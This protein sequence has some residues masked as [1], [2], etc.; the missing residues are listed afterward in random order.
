MNKLYWISL[1][2]ATFGVITDNYNI[3]TEAAPIGKWMIGKTIL[4]VYSWVL[5]KRGEIKEIK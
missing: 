5:K 1:S 4:E 2:Y 3:I